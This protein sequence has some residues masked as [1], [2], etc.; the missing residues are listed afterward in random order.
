MIKFVGPTWSCQSRTQRLARNYSH[1]PCPLIARV[2]RCEDRRSRG[3]NR[4]SNGRNA[5][6]ELGVGHFCQILLRSNALRFSTACRRHEHFHVINALQGCTYRA[7]TTC[8]YQFSEH[9]G[10]ITRLPSLLYCEESRFPLPSP[11][12]RPQRDPGCHPGR[13]LTLSPRRRRRG[14]TEAATVHG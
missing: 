8:A 6:T 12:P 9:A 7:G 14:R 11:G 13:G 4:H 3:A 5:P 1:K 2:L 10:T